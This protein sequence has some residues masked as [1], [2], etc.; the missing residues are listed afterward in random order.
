MHFVGTFFKMFPDLT[1]RVTQPIQFQ[2]PPPPL[3]M[4]TYEIYCIIASKPNSVTP[5]TKFF[6]S[7]G[8]RE[9]HPSGSPSNRQPVVLGNINSEMPA[10]HR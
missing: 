3:A 10:F 2:L 5:A 8:H 7:K 1:A 4:L 9:T 6:F